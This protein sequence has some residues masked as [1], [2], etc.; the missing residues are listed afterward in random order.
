MN[1]KQHIQLQPYN[2]FRTKAR[3]KLFCEPGSVEELSKVLRIYPDEPKLVIG[4]G[5][6]LF[7]T[8]D[9]DGLV[10][11]PAMRGICLLSE[12]DSTVELEAAAGEDWDDFV[13][14]CVK[15]G[16]AGI[17]NLSLIPG[18]VGAA[19]IQNIG[20]Y[21]T[22]VKDAIVR[23]HTV[24]KNTGKPETFSAEACEFGYRDSIFKRTRQHI[25]TSVVFRLSKSFAYMEKYADLNRELA[26]VAYPS[27]QQV[28]EA[29]I[30]IRRCKLPDP[31]ELPNAG[32]FFKNPLLTMEEKERLLTKLPDAPIYPIGTDKFKTSA[33]FLIEKA[34][35]KGKR[36]ESVGI[37]E[38]HALI[39]VNYATENGSDI[40]DFMEEVQQAVD[41][42]FGI[43]L[44]PEVRIY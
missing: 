2:S 44:E 13:N 21:G 1:V 28:R 34:G 7:F 32:S 37:Y 12:N 27:L 16:Y 33:A 29:I 25:V 39:I 10:I 36:N 22:E 5:C 24:N 26:S 6:N 31:A 14:Y 4:S 42:K 40:I 3:A 35:Y 9:F 15:K 41:E 38:R 30:R 20:A 17:E 18:T 23:V 43:L 19:P 8:K 11:H